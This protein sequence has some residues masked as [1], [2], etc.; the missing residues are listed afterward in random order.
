MKLQVLLL[1]PST[2]EV[3][4]PE[5]K[6]YEFAT[7][8]EKD[9]EHER[10]SKA[11]R[12]FEIMSKVKPVAIFSVCSTQDFAKHFQFLS[13]LPHHV[14]RK[15]IHLDSISHFHENMINQVFFTV[16]KGHPFAKDNPL[17]SV[18][19][20]TFH[21]GDKLLRPLKCML[22]QTY[23]N[24]EWIIWDDSK[25]D[26]MWPRLEKIA[27]LDHRIKVFRPREHSGFIGEM[28]SLA[29]S[30]AQ[31]DWLVEIDHDDEFDT[32]L[33][34]WIARASKAHPDVDFIYTDSSEIY[35]ES[36]K[37]HTYGDF[38]AFGFG[39]HVHEWHE[40][41]KR[42]FAPAVTQGPNP[43][44]LQHIVGVPNHVRA[45]KTCLY[46]RIGKH[47]A[48]LPVCDDYDLLLRTFLH[49]KWLHIPV[50][51]YMQYRNANGNNF[52]FLR[53]ELIQHASAWLW[54]KN[55]EDVQN[56]FKELGVPLESPDPYCEVW[57]LEKELFPTLETVWLPEPFNTKTTVSIICPTFDRSD[58]LL[59]AIRSVCAQTDKD[60]ILFVIGDKCPTLD[61]TMNSLENMPDIRPFLFRIRW[62]NLSK[63]SKK[64]GAVSRNYALNRLAKTDWVAYLDDDNAWLPNHLSTLRAAAHLNPNAEAVFASLLVQDKPILCTEAVFGRVDASSFM[65]KRSLASE[66]GFWP[67]NNVGYAN[68]WKFV[69]PWVAADVEFAFTKHATLVYNTSTNDQ[70]FESIRA[71]KPLPIVK[72]PRKSKAA[73]SPVLH[74]VPESIDLVRDDRKLDIALS[75]SD[76]YV[77]F[78]EPFA[79]DMDVVLTDNCLFKESEVNSVT[80]FM[81]LRALASSASAVTLYQ[82]EQLSRANELARVAREVREAVARGTRVRVLQYSKFN[83]R[84]L[85]KALHDV[86]FE[87]VYKPLVTPAAEIRKLQALLQALVRIDDIGFSCGGS[88]RRTEVVARLRELGFK[89][90]FIDHSFGQERDVG[91]ASCHVLL[92]IHAAEDF[93]VFETSRCLRW[94]EAGHTVVTEPSEDLEEYTQRFPNLIVL[95]FADI[96]QGRFGPR[97]PQLA[98]GRPKDWIDGVLSAWTGHRSFAEWLVGRMKPKVVVDLGMDFGYS[99][100]VFAAAGKPHGTEVFGIDMFEADINTGPRQTFETVKAQIK[101]HAL[102]NLTVLRAEFGSVAK[103]WARAVD[104]LH[105]DGLHSFEAVKADFDAWSPHVRAGGVILFHDTNVTAKESA[106][107]MHFKVKE[108]FD[109]LPQEFCHNFLH[110]AGLGVFTKNKELL[111]EIRAF[112]ASA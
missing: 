37:C 57:H 84:V 79:H 40:A 52:T 53:N 66:F 106:S 69:E 2:S 58:L 47:N 44:T 45:W 99:T 87:H 54:D 42:W 49:G 39:A 50:C 110:S 103:V 102:D 77:G 63:Q 43:R 59:R 56:K 94:L 23:M 86:N 76:R 10:A 61:A 83:M 65:H 60:W 15:W 109:T 14:V 41:S 92:N 4:V 100:F 31:G 70:T 29:C 74:S 16:V 62:W 71:L 9:L 12:L 11:E 55:K 17:M 24:W 96:M 51:A 89:V 101:E 85:A 20:S 19:T 7:V 22:Q 36:K 90:R 46:N 32:H 25:D 1:R 78:F 97:L 68:D 93:Q 35:E 28:K 111:A 38:F 30:V 82:T 6:F 80:C 64:W 112:N 105:I 88:D 107:F 34:E 98:R 33:L 8:T 26:S 95:P 104:I 91:I 81:T 67:M 75:F 27:E 72:V 13:L 21:S 48:L 5:T 108:F 73:I 3:S 18:I